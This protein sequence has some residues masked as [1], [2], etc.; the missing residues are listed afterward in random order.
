MKGIYTLIIEIKKDVE[1]KIGSL[2]KI[3][4]KKGTYIYVGSAQN[5]LKKRILRHLSTEKKIKW[6]IDYLLKNKNVEVKKVF[7]KLAKKQEE[8]ITAR[9]LLKTEIPILKFGCSDCDCKSHLFKVRNL[10]FIKK[11]N[12][13]E[14]KK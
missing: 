9:E 13:R 7:F 8:C 2:N 12:F 3:L 5:N 14:F 11:L 4:F 1:I 10:S 6:H